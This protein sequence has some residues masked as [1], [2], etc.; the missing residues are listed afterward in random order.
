MRPRAAVHVTDHVRSGTVVSLWYETGVR[1]GS[2]PG[3]RSDQ[4][5]RVAIDVTPLIGARSGVGGALADIID[6]LGALDVPPVLLPYALSL[7]ARRA[8]P[9]LPPDTHFVPLPARFLLRAWVRFD[10]PR[11][12]AFL[13]RADVVHA[14]NYLTPP[15]RHAALVTVYDLSFVRFPELCTPE[16]RAFDPV[17]Q[18][19]IGRGAVVHTSSEFVAAEIEERYG[20]GLLENDR[21]V[22]VPLGVSRLGD[23]S[24]LPPSM[25]DRL[26]GA[27]YILAIGTLEPRKNYPALVRAFAK[28]A[29]DDHDVRLVIAG[30][31]GPACAAVDAEVANLPP[32]ARSR[33]V[34]GGA[35]DDA[36]RRALLEG[37]AVVVYPSLYEG[38]GLPVLEAMACGVPVVT[39]RVGAIP[40]VAGDAALLVDPN[41]TDAL[42]GEVARVL[43]DGTLRASLVAR[44]RDR[45]QQFSWSATARGLDTLYRRLAS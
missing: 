29:A 4:G 42:A 18:R 35:V 27:P 6:A 5:P 22:V 12:D 1:D 26:G 28:I 20:P 9:D 33:V 39:T 38:F 41:D 21:V 32:V 14:T 34:L 17:L 43:R 16:V 19:A 7:R 40:E 23:A 13:G 10:W 11:V 31:D 37:A 36:A 2:G 15:T 44:G 3:T 25:R 24:R 30:R 45:A 8:R